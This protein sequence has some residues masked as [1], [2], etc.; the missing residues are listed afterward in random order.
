MNEAQALI[1]ELKS[2]GGSQVLIAK[3]LHTTT[4][5]IS[6]IVHG[7][8]SGKQTLPRLRLLVMQIRQARQQQ[9][10]ARAVVVSQPAPAPVRQAAR[11]RVVESLPVQIIQAPAPPPAKRPAPAR[12]Y[13]PDL[14]PQHAVSMQ[15]EQAPPDVIVSPIAYAA[16][17]RP[18]TWPIGVPVHP[19]PE[20]K[21]R[22]AWPHTPE[23][24]NQ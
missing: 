3:M 19:P 4:V 15:S 9:P 1:E 11:P 6:R 7:E 18:E 14:L 22:L 12:R 23:R 17:Y 13:L 21:V 2:Y 10:P 24:W 20:L 8:R 16:F 5:N